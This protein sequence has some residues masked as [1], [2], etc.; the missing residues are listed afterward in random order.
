MSTLGPLSVAQPNIRFRLDVGDTFT[1]D[2]RGAWD[3]WWLAGLDIL[4]RM[5]YSKPEPVTAIVESG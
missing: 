1:T 4:E 5:K 2:G 3:G